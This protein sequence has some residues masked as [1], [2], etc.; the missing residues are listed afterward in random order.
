MHLTL[1]NHEYR[2]EREVEDNPR[3]EGMFDMGDLGYADN[4]WTVHDFLEILKLDGVE[5]SHYFTS[6][7][8]GRPVTS[9]AALLRE[10]QCSAVMGHVQ[11]TDMAFHKKTQNIAM[12]AGICYLHDE[13]YLGPQGNQT[14]RQVVMLHEV[15]DGK[16]DPMFV[17]LRF[18]QKRYS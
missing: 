16:F 18:L 1:G 9:A 8:M 11:H 5:Y 17:S 4:G 3:L 13:K 7:N 2:M 10:R 15:E 14:R 6:G 12:F